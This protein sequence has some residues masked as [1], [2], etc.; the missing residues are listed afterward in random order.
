MSPSEKLGRTR[1]L[2]ALGL[3]LFGFALLTLALL[4]D[5]RIKPSPY[6]TD[7]PQVVDNGN[8]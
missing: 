8:K 7:T 6:D 2:G 5:A 4:L 3:L 1:W